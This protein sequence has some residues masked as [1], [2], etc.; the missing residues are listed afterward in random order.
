MRI[1]IA[2]AEAG[3]GFVIDKTKHRVAGTEVADPNR[4][5]DR[6]RASDYLATR[7]RRGA[8]LSRGSLPPSR[9]SRRAL[10][11]SINAF[12]ASRTKAVLSR[13]PVRASAS[14]RSRSSKANVVR[15]V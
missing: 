1:D 14:S 3:Q 2:D 8:D 5:I 7:R 10:S 13:S 11:R 9:A 4:R 15:I 12:N 6:D